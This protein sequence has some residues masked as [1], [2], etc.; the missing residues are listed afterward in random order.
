MRRLILATI[1]TYQYA[2][3]PFLGN[4]CR[5]WP[6]CSQYAVEAIETHGPLKGAMLTIRR[7]GR[8]HPWHDGGY[9]PVPST[10]HDA[11]CR[12]AHDH[13]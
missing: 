11:N 12:H 6:S 13:D 2:I 3:S 4:H 5:F 9:D 1:K 8:C 7:I 10:F